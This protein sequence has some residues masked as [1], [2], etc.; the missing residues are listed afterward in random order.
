MP[1]LRVR[2]RA[3][4]E[5]AEAVG[6]RLRESG[7]VAVS[8]KPC[9]ERDD[10]VLEPSPTGAGPQLWPTVR[11]EALL[12]VDADLS[13]L[14]PLDCDVDFM[15]DEDWSETWRNGFG[16]LRFGRLRVIPSTDCK[17][18]ANAA[19]GEAII[20]LDPGLAFGTGTHPTT[21]LCL[22]WLAEQDLA[23]KRVLDVGTGSGILAIAAL[24]LGA[25]EAVAID[26][27]PQARR[28]CSRNAS[29][30]GVRLSI[31]SDID[32]A[33]GPFD[34]VLANIVADVLCDMASA[35]SARCRSRGSSSADAAK[36][37]LSGILV[38]QTEQVMRA[39]SHVRPRIRFRPPVVG[40]G[41][42]LLCGDRND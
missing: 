11:V 35:L 31:A 9:D 18:A 6:E 17:S 21:A 33:S 7:A 39:Y 34:V 37:A 8:L 20:R 15:A 27:D 19:P 2:T 41:W 4:R 13:A 3:E 30:N 16:E 22:R 1:W 14:R 10:G 32:E 25:R 26:H 40:E 12:P 28:A 42:A 23:G 29:A 24:R 38:R 5:R 36:L